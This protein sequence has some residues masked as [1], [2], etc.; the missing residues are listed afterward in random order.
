M[1][2]SRGHTVIPYILSNSRIE[3]LSRLGVALGTVWSGETYK[4]IKSL[5]ERYRF[6]IVHVHNFFPLV[7][8]SVYYAAHSVGVPVIQTLHNF[9]LLCCNAVLFR[10]GNI[11]ETCINE[12]I[13]WSGFRYACYQENRLLS[14]ITAAS[15]A[16]HHCMGTWKHKVNRYIALTE[17]AKK[18][19]I[20]G[21]IPPKKIAVKSNFMEF[22]P[23]VSLQE[24]DFALFVGRLTAEKGIHT[25]L[26]AWRRLSNVSL[27]IAG[28]G[29][30]RSLVSDAAASNSLITY[31]GSVSNE[32][33]LKLIKTSRFVLVPSEW[34]EHFPMII[35]ESF[36]CARPVL[37]SNIGSLKEIITSGENGILFEPGD[38]RDLADQAAR[39]WRHKDLT[40]KLARNARKCYEAKYTEELNYRQLIGIYN[41]DILKQHPCRISR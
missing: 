37:A 1:L 22:D 14:G 41:M 10:N 21:G 28:D 38:F 4:N 39:L 11:C 2:R 33:V 32:R 20:A 27:M 18:K 25:L 17:F 5:I 9:R 15:F 6:D 23:G 31:L 30:L 29:P 13:G 12:S 3:R 35:I 7:S 26:R 34:Y 16:I 8:P 36:S 40:K 24:G 19:F